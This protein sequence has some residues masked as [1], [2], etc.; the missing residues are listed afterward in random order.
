MSFSK[1]LALLTIAGA[2]PMAA[3][4]VEQTEDATLPDIEAEGGEMPEFDI[5]PANVRV[6]EDTVT[7]P[8]IDLEAPQDAVADEEAILEVE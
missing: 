6:S 1:T 7:V 3:C 2:L 4:Q 5:E 8:D